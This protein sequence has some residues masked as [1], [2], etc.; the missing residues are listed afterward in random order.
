MSKI[1]DRIKGEIDAKRCPVHHKKPNIS[2]A[3]DN[4]MM[5]CC[6]TAFEVEC[7]ARIIEI[8]SSEV[9]KSKK[10]LE[11]SSIAP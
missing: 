5:V 11:D 7:Y 8:L 10:E 6:C 2:I 4:V 3:N 1:Y 9:K